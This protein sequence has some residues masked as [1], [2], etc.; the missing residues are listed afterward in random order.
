MQKNRR[1]LII[2]CQN[3]SKNLLIIVL[4]SMCIYTQ[5]FLF[6]NNCK[7]AKNEKKRGKKMYKKV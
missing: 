7:R 2:Q 4:S 3:S 5:L 6:S 1:W